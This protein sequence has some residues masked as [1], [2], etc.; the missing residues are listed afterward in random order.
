M[1]SPEYYSL[2]CWQKL[3]VKFKQSELIKTAVDL[4]HED[5]YIE[6]TVVTVISKC[7]NSYLNY[8]NFARFS[9][10]QNDKYSIQSIRQLLNK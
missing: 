4:F 6:M 3:A 9:W 8:I 10:H 7:F 5:Q 2:V 1:S